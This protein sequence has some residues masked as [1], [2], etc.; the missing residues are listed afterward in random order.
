MGTNRYIVGNDINDSSNVLARDWDSNAGVGASH[1][2][3]LG[4][5]ID[6]E[7]SSKISDGIIP[8]SEDHL[9]DMDI[10]SDLTMS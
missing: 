7:A 4:I 9:D 1:T 3:E 5:K 8:E 10:P 6:D 2:R